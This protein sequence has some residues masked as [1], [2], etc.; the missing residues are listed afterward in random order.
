MLN[1]CRWEPVIC[2]RAMLGVL[3]LKVFDELD[4]RLRGD[5]SARVDPHGCETTLIDQLVELR[6]ADRES[7][8]GFVW[9]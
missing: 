5:A 1:A 8:G 9:G 3:P 4:E 2:L 7:L 6:S